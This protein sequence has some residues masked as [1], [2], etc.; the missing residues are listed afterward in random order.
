VCFSHFSFLRRTIEDKA[1][2]YGIDL[3]KGLVIP[4]AKLGPKY[5]EFLEAMGTM[6]HNRLRYFDNDLLERLTG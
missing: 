1:K 2:E 4:V 6:P 5:Q 3:T